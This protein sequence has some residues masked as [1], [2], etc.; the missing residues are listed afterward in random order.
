MKQIRSA[1]D[2]RVPLIGFSGSPFTLASYM[3]EGGGSD[4]FRL[5]KKLAYDR[6]DLMQHLLEVN[7]DAVA[8]YLN[9][10]IR[11]GAQAVM[12]FDTWGGVLNP[13]HYRQYS[14]ASM[15]RVVQQLQRENEGRRV[16]VI[17][18]TK[19]GG[20]WL[21]DMAGMGVD[22]LGLDW[23][24]DLARARQRVGHQVALQGNFDPQALY[25]QPAAIEQEVAR[26]LA[27]FGHGSGHV[28]NLGHGIT[29]ATPIEHV[30][31]LVDAVHRLSP[32]YHAAS[33]QG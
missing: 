27:E 3:V 22:G 10:Q 2:G 8:T 13:V 28:F 31:A 20:A 4:D 5:I 15:Q 6:P 1:L 17:A 12:I 16:P 26:L 25:A 14:L 23:T 19:G 32:A 11:A 29:P 18:F 33:N 30:A 7:A 21:E 9:A 24:V